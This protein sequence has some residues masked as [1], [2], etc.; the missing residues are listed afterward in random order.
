MSEVGTIIYAQLVF[1][2]MPGE[3]LASI[4]GLYH[5]MPNPTQKPNSWPF[6]AREQ[7]FNFNAV[8]VDCNEARYDRATGVGQL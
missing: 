1:V 7:V 5:R 3:D 8:A 6:C 2:A 4:L